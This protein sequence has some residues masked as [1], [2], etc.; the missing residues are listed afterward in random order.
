[1]SP[2]EIVTLAAAVLLL[3]TNAAALQMW[4]R[5]RA[6]RDLAVVSIE[7]VAQ[8]AERAINTIGD[9]LAATIAERDAARAQA[10]LAESS[11]VI[12]E[13]GWNRAV[14]ALQAARKPAPLT[15]G[16]LDRIPAP[17]ALQAVPRG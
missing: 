16:S 11:A 7:S 15:V 6:E 13:A 10:A 12:A 9:E 8:S 14:D 3:L 5:V 17:R 2:A 4:R 1:M